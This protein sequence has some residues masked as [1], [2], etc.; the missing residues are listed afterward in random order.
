MLSE[1]IIP[2]TV[3]LREVIGAKTLFV[4]GIPSPTTRIDLFPMRP[5]VFPT[6]VRRF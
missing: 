4:I 2:M 5:S 1:T 3:V 6:G